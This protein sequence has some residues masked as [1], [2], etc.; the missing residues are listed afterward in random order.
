MK[1]LDM[2]A[3]VLLIIGGLNWLLVALF[4]FDLVASLFGGQEAVLARIIYGLVGLS[5]LWCMKF[6]SYRPK[7]GYNNTTTDRTD[8]A[9]RTRNNHNDTV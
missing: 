7:T 4:Q 8:R 5:A 1:G 6:F 9:D 3:L 2:T